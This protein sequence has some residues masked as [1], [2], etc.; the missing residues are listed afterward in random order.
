MKPILLL[1]AALLAG[2]GAG[3]SEDAAGPF[4]TVTQAELPVAAVQTEPPLAAVPDGNSPEITQVAE[5]EPETETTTTEAPKEP[6]AL[7]TELLEGHSFSASKFPDQVYSNKKLKKAFSAIDD[8]CADY[9]WSLSFVYKNMNTGATCAYNENKYYGCCSTIKAPFCKSILEMNTDLDETIVINDLW[10]PAAGT[11][12][13]SGYGS[14]FTARE[15]IKLAITESDNS[16]YLNLVDRYGFGA[17]NDMNS[18]LGAGYYLG[19]GYIFNE[20]TAN[21]LMKEYTDIYKYSQKSK[22]GDWLVRLMQ[23]TELET[24]ITAELS[25]KYPVA[26]KYGSDWEQLCYHDCAICYADSPFVLVIMTNQEPETEE[27]NE[28]F[29]RLAKQFDI[30]NGQLVT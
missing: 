30:V 21:D 8:I 13:D 2:C 15:L 19:Y 9:G 25:D 14:K 26:H 16:A 6:T 7:K 24:Q 5:T 3:S 17:F 12:A 28:V 11:V 27:S 10:L 18:K 1:S 4:T 22:R 20:C 23:K 29:R